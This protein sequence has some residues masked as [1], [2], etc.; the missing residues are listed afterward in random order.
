MSLFSRSKDGSR[1]EAVPS[2]PL[3][4]YL[5]SEDAGLRTRIDLLMEDV[6]S[7]SGIADVLSKFVG[8]KTKANYVERIRRQLEIIVLNVIQT[9]PVGQ[10][11]GMPRGK[12][13]YVAESLF[14]PSG[15]T[16]E[17]VDVADALDELGLLGVHTDREQN[18]VSRIIPSEDFIRLIFNQNDESNEKEERRL[19][20]S[21]KSSECGIVLKVPGRVWYIDK[22]GMKR[23]K[24]TDVRVPFK[25]LVE[26]D[27]YEVRAA[28]LARWQEFLWSFEVSYAGPDYERKGLVLKSG[29]QISRTIKR[30]FRDTLELPLR[31]YGAWQQLPAHDDEKKK[32]QDLR[33]YIQING[34]R[35]LELDFG[36]FFPV[37]ILTQIGINWKERFPSKDAYQL[38]R[39]HH[40]A[41][42][43]QERQ[44]LRGFLK[45][46]F[47][48]YCFDSIHTPDNV[49]RRLELDLCDFEECV[50]YGAP[51]QANAPAF[52]IIARLKKL[53]VREAV[54][55]VV[56]EYCSMFDGVDE[57]LMDWK[58]LQQQ[59]SKITELVLD[60]CI[61]NNIPCL[62]IHDGYRL[63]NGHHYQVMNF[64]KAAS[65]E[66][67]G[68]KNFFIKLEDPEGPESNT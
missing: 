29:M 4:V 19:A 25:K 59:E 62:P 41:A 27:Y 33:R 3:D 9:Y 54:D 60:A 58:L 50:R 23:R 11:I 48:R 15:V 66:V 64:M 40:A 26:L 49:I 51:E 37:L 36:C 24:S 14:G 46:V 52:G 38:E 30:H 45:T 1:T 53:P 32:T 31:F 68:T 17:I 6:H 34:Q 44:A 61:K 20:L 35:T 21:L 56:R 18:F 63:I 22:A 7:T 42:D 43:R 8:E 5:T 28:E 47:A 65:E 55:Q 57:S 10:T 16:R 13:S 12:N 2:A 67:T 39:L